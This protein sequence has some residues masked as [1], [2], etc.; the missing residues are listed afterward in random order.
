MNGIFCKKS[1]FLLL[2]VGCFFCIFG[3]ENFF[4]GEKLF[5]ENKPAEAINYLRLAMT[6]ENVDKKV[7]NYLGLCYYQLGKN[8]ESLDT[9]LKGTTISGTNKRQLFYNAGNSAFALGQFSRAVEFYSYSLVADGTFSNAVLN[10]ANA[11]FIC[12][13]DPGHAHQENCTV[14]RTIEQEASTTQEGK[15]K[16]TATVTYNG[17]GFNASR[18]VVQAKLTKLT[19][20]G[21]DSNSGIYT[22][23]SV[24][25]KAPKTTIGSELNVALAKDLLTPA[26]TANYDAVNVATDV[27]VYLEVQNIN[28]AV[29]S[30][31][32]GKVE[33]QI[34][35]LVTEAVNTAADVEVETGTAYV[36]LSMYKNVKTEVKTD[37]EVISESNTTDHR[38]RKRD[39]DHDGSSRGHPDG[40]QR[41]YQNLQGNPCT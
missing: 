18:T 39:H 21:A 32:A 25:E 27:T 31:E 2:F 23:A 6:E 16:Y 12:T 11:Y 17:K 34:A 38:Y 22:S 29:S 40:D 24:A 26:E 41:I 9:F 33:A 15:V 13:R 7:Y 30:E 20:S 10:R 28:G 3:S 19:D 1:L 14:P 5:K 36:D 4:L 35:D 37:S 8:Q